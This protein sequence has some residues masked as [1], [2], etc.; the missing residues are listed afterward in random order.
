MKK[1]LSFLAACCMAVG[2]ASAEPVVQYEYTIAL[3]EVTRTGLYTGN[4]NDD[5][6]PD[7][8]GVFS[9]IN[10]NN[11]PWYYIGEWKDGTFNGHGVQVWE[12]GKVVEGSFE[13]SEEVNTIIYF[14]GR[15]FAEEIILAPDDDESE[16]HNIVRHYKYDSEGNMWLYFERYYYLDPYVTYVTFYDSHGRMVFSGV[17]GDGWEDA[18]FSVH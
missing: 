11:E 5:G 4:L 6:L 14:P 16:E 8:F 7:G 18:Y 2:V 15:D 13:K 3:P 9:T 12:M 10:D 17:T 1:V